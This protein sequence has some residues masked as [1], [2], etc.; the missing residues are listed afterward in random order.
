[1]RLIIIF[2]KSYMRIF[3]FIW[4]A[5]KTKKKSNLKNIVEELK[6]GATENQSPIFLCYGFYYR[7]IFNKEFLFLCVFLLY[8]LLKNITVK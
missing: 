1:M 3:T 4:I 5:Y 8:H 7:A 6:L 2:D